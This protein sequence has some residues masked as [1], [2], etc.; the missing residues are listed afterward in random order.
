M[1]TLTL[2]LPPQALDLLNSLDDKLAISGAIVDAVD[3]RQTQAKGGQETQDLL[4]RGRDGSQHTIT[5]SDVGEFEARRGQQMYLLFV[6]D[7]AVLLYNTRTNQHMLPENADS[8]RKRGLLSKALGPLDIVDIVR[9]F[10]TDPELPGGGSRALRELKSNVDKMHAE[11]AKKPVLPPGT[12]R[13][14]IAAVLVGA[15]GFGVFYF[16]GELLGLLRRDGNRP[17]EKGKSLVQY[18]DLVQLTLEET[19]A[20]S[21]PQSGAPECELVGSIYNRMGRKVDKLKFSGRVRGTVIAF[22]IEG[23]DKGAER[24]TVV[25]GRHPGACLPSYKDRYELTEP[26]CMFDG[27]VR[28]GCRDVIRILF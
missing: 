18:L 27:V 20:G 6:G 17:Y 4:V 7:T 15:I 3:V 2:P 26:E 28:N 13:Y 10:A 1:A 16:G 25:L 22:D 21:N 8:T 19:R 5:L 14:A 24:H 23:L 9:S 12:A 11:R